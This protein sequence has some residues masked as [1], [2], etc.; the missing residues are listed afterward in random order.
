MLGYKHFVMCKAAFP[1]CLIVCGVVAPVFGRNLWH[2]LARNCTIRRLAASRN[3]YCIIRN[4]FLGPLIKVKKENRSTAMWQQLSKFVA[5]AV[6][7]FCTRK[8][9]SVHISLSSGL[10]S[11]VWS[12]L[13]ISRLGWA[14]MQIFARLERQKCQQ[15]SGLWLTTLPCLHLSLQPH[16]QGT[17]RASPATLPCAVCQS[18]VARRIGP[19]LALGAGLIIYHLINDC[20]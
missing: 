3:V 17:P 20:V 12:C 19:L 1:C 7:H 13:S 5:A 2:F 8:Y 15:I 18:L 14:I 10:P 9:F 6:A 16:N 4:E 11:L